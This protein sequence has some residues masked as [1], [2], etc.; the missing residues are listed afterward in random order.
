MPIYQPRV[1]PGNE[2]GTVEA[3]GRMHGFADVARVGIANRDVVPYIHIGGGSRIP[4]RSWRDAHWPEWVSKSGAATGDTQGRVVTRQPIKV[5]N[6]ALGS[7][8][9]Q[10]L[11][12]YASAGGDSGSP[13][14]LFGPT[15]GVYAVIV[16]IHWGRAPC[17]IT[18]ID[19]ATFSPISGIMTE[20][21]GWEP[22]TK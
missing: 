2:A 11:A 8:Q 10:V 7:L 14:F 19:R 21:S 6:P 5:W 20:L 15:G 9:N 16:G 22:H 13:V 12:A 18:G 4:V 17:P 1:A 3:V